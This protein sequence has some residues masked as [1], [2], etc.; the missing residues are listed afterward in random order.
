MYHSS[1][2]PNLSN[3][4]NYFCPKTTVLL[5]C[6]VREAVSNG[7]ALLAWACF[8]FFNRTQTVS[9]YLQHAFVSYSNTLCNAKCKMQMRAHILDVIVWC[10]IVCT[11]CF[12]KVLCDCRCSCVYPPSPSQHVDHRQTLSQHCFEW[13]L[14]KHAHAVTELRSFLDR[15]L[16]QSS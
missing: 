7:Y 11:V 15:N 1:T 13:C 10:R 14:K 12:W 2:W 16:K 3:E 5:N 9:W 6:F 8:A 4:V